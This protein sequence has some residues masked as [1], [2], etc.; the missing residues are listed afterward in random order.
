MTRLIVTFRNFART[1]KRKLP[2]SPKHV[3]FLDRIIHNE[4]FFFCVSLLTFP[5]CFL[6]VWL[7]ACVDLTL[8]TLVFLSP[9]VLLSSYCTS[10]THG[11]ALVV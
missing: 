10:L 8:L 9:Q 7:T 1:H 4:I 3:C 2:I 11:L 6:I 5:T